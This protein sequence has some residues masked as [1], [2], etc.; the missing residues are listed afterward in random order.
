MNILLVAATR[1]EIAPFIEAYEAMPTDALTHDITIAL[2]GVGGV[3]SAVATLQMLHRLH[4]TPHKPECVIQAGIAGAFT[5]RLEVG[6]VVEIASERFAQLGA[7]DRDGTFLDAFHHLHLADPN[8]HPFR[9]AKIALQP[10]PAFFTALPKAAAATA[11]RVS[12]TEASIAALRRA[13]PEVEVESME[14]AAVAYACAVFGC[15]YFTQI[16]AISNAIEPR[17]RA[18]WQIGRAVKALNEV[19]IQQLL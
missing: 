16:R 17:N 18:A 8:A 6:D 19:L 12:G 2:T 15:V 7:E 11:D 14:G 13:H 9:E 5:D 4:R 3:M 10:H 1:A